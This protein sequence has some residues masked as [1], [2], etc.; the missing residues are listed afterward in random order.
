M[1]IIYII[2]ILCHF[3]MYCGYFYAAVL[4]DY[5]LQ[6]GN[7]FGLFFCATLYCLY[8]L[9]L[10][11]SNFTMLCFCY[12]KSWSSCECVCVCDLMGFDGVCLKECAILHLMSPAAEESRG[13]A[14]WLPLSLTCRLSTHTHLQAH[15]HLTVEHCSNQHPSPPHLPVP[16][17]RRSSHPRKG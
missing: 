3:K 16:Q 12:G 1:D 8:S 7:N 6:N 13:G 5:C 15:T 11:P 10:L 4:C 14:S 9:I 2:F 17:E